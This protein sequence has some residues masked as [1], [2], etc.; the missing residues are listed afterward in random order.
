MCHFPGGSVYFMS[1]H[2]V[3]K[4]APRR[5]EQRDGFSL[6][7]VMISLVILAIGVLA[8]TELQLSVTKGNGSSDTMATA[9]SLAE[10]KMESL[11]KASYTTIQAEPPTAV[12]ASGGTFSREVIVT[13]NQPML[14][15][16]TVQVIVTG[17]DGQR[18]FTVP[19]STVIAQ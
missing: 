14:N 7:E 12:T 16:K 18:T 2:P 11:K 6:I 4:S 8:L 5:L 13:S 9:L 19:L 3:S 15:V 10:Q 1:K 17:T